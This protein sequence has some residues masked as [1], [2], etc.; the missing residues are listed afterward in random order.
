MPDKQFQ[1][2]KEAT[3]AAADDPGANDHFDKILDNLQADATEH[4]D[5]AVSIMREALAKMTVAGSQCTKRPPQ[6][7]GITYVVVLPVQG[8]S[9]VAVSVWSQS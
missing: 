3:K 9:C 7:L 4:M 1:E 2:T 5:K 6:L 8:F